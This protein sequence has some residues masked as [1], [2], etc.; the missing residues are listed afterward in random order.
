MVSA[1][2]AAYFDDELSLEFI[3]DADISQAGLHLM[4]SPPQPRK[5]FWAAAGRCYLGASVHVGLAHSEGINR[6]QPK[7]SSVHKLLRED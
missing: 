7:S 6:V 4:G 2:A 5:M 3:R 1:A